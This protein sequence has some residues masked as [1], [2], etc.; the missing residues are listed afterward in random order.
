MA[1][2]TDATGVV[3]ATEPAEA[4]ASAGPPGPAR[5]TVPAG[6]P[7]PDRSGAGAASGSSR[8]ERHPTVTLTVD[9]DVVTVPDE[10]GSLLDALREHLGMRQVKDG[11]SPQGQCGCCT[12]LVDGQPRVSCVTALRRVA[13]RQVVTVDGLDPAVRARWARALVDHGASQCGFCSPGIVLRLV[14][15]A[16]RPKRGR[17]SR[18]DAVPAGAVPL[19]AVPADAV[20]TDGVRVDAS[21]ADAVREDAVRAE[22]ARALSAHLCRCTGWQTIVDA[23]V[24]VLTDAEDR[25]EAPGR[26]APADEARATDGR[27]LTAAAQRATV[28]GGTP[29]QV[30]PAAA[31]GG[32]GFADDTAP[33]D[34]WVAVPDG[35]GEWMVAP[36]LAEARRRAGR[37]PGRNS[38]LPV[39]HP[40]A[41]PPGPWVLRLA[42]TFVE[43]AYV[44]PDASWCPPGGAPTSPLANG[45]AF[46]GKATS[47]APAVARRLADELGRP[48]RVLLGREDVVRLGPKR[49][50]IAAGVAADGTGVVRVARTP[51]ADLDGWAEALVSVAPGL[52]VEVV[53]V[54]GPPVSARLRGAGWVEGAVLTAA[55]SWLANGDRRAPL[56]VTTPAGAWAAA[57]VADDG[58]VAVSVRAG[59]VLD[60]VVLRSYAIGAAHQA[61]GWVRSEAVAVDEDG[62]VHDL[63]I[64]SY[65]IVPARST[66]RITVDVLDDDGPPVPGG[67]AVFAA[68]A[69]AC[70]A[71]S[72]FAERWP[73]E[74]T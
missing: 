23:A 65:G 3:V 34:A 18:G 20:P 60:P 26:P 63:T 14:G 73:T 25:A 8:P 47:P 52:T 6:P 39:R 71:A 50:P 64:R 54:P 28:E 61:V 21:P 2:A 67:D 42:T 59:R 72:G 11:C 31:L 15:L 57:T 43:P 40:L 30:G 41:V 35:R 10:G 55:A 36:T 19:G 37:T 12:V 5:A 9:G 1:P 51:G 7:G 66:P 44:E 4:T 45:G 33:A 29:Q 68:A 17:S 58:A 56:T 48:V 24:A 13:G 69:A 70:W 38:T 46:G 49:P 62:A 27:D 22:V 53:E 32:A 16:A 74:R